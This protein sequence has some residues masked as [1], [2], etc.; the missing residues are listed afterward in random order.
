MSEAAMKRYELVVLFRAELEAKLDDSLKSIA[1]LITSNGGK[2]V[3]EDAWGRK[4]LAYKIQ[5]ETHAIYRVYELELPAA[6]PA[7]IEGVLNINSAVIR[8]LLVKID[9]KAEASL[10]AEKAKREAR[11]PKPEEDQ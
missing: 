11:A 4:E 6:A 7:K 2:I 9:A 3:K 8:H 10:A 1:D 5:G